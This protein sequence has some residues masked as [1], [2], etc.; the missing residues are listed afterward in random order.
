MPHSLLP[1][2]SAGRM[3]PGVTPSV[4][5]L[6]NTMIADLD[7]TLRQLLRRD[8]A[9]NGFE[10]VEISFE[11]PGREWSAQL[12]VPT[13]NLFLY[14]LRE[15]DDQRLAEW[16]TVKGAE[17]VADVRPPMRLD[18]SFAV[19]AWTRDVED[20]HRLLSQVISILFAY[21][22]LPAD[23]LVGRLGEHAWQPFPLSTRVGRPRATGGPEF[24]TALGTT[25]KASIDF[26]VTLSVASGTTLER[27]PEVRLPTVSLRDRDRP[28]GRAE[29]WHRLGGRVVTDD[30]DPV[31]DAWVLVGDGRGIALTD[32]SGRFTFERVPSGE[33]ALR[34]RAAT[35]E[36][37]EAVARIPGRV[38]DL[39]ISPA[40]R[41][42]SPSR[43]S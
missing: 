28:R 37:A 36:V 30:G 3:L 19:T 31:Q 40:K 34:V 25:Y 6:V 18:L 8:L 35:G 1:P 23:V 11:A 5:V 4:Q 20:E 42:K 21:P 7:E 41:R 24:W 39:V 2:S 9:A 29:Q 14:D 17:G 13:V 16:E 26:R 32:A 43:K 27:G 15:S 10:G 33:H 12:S 22:S 38:P